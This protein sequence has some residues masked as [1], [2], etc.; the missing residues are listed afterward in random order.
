VR[1]TL[2]IPKPL[3]SRE[4]SPFC[5]TTAPS[6]QFAAPPFCVT[7]SAAARARHY[8]SA[9][10]THSPIESPVSILRHSPERRKGKSPLVLRHR[11]PGVARKPRAINYL[12]PLQNQIRALHFAS[13]PVRH[14]HAPIGF[15]SPFFVLGIWRLGRA[16]VDGRGINCIVAR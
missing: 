14:P 5:V 2:P 15:V 12:R 6:P 10:Y 9:A 4:P 3:K 11:I 1:T 7:K 13:Q 16:V 8:K